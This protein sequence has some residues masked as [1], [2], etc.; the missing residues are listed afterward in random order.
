MRRLFIVFLLNGIFAISLGLPFIFLQSQPARGGDSISVKSSSKDTESG[1]EE[2]K[3]GGVS[4]SEDLLLKEELVEPQDEQEVK[5]Q[6]GEEL[7]RPLSIQKSAFQYG[8]GKPR[9]PSYEEWLRLEA[10]I[11]RPS[12]AVPKKAEL[13][14]VK[15]KIAIPEEKPIAEKPKEAEKPFSFPPISEVMPTEQAVSLALK[16]GAG[17]LT[18]DY[19]RIVV[20]S[21]RLSGSTKTKTYDMEGELLLFYRDITASA[22]RARLEEKTERILLQDDVL[23]QDPK[24][25]LSA[26]IV[27]IEFK[28][29]RFTAENFV[30]FK[31]KEKGKEPTGKDVPKR[32][33]VINIFKNEPTEIYANKLSYNWESEEM[34][35]EGEVKALQK[36]FTATMDKLSY[37]PRTKLYSLSGNVFVTLE[38]AEFL[39]TYELVEKEDED[40]ARALSEK[41]SVLKADSIETGE[42]TDV[43]LIR[44]TLAQPAEMSQEGKYLRALQIQ[45]DDFKK[46]LTA[47]G[48]VE[49]YQENGEWLKKGGLVEEGADEEVKKVLAKPVTSTSDYLSYDYDKRILRQWGAV[50][51]IS[52]NEALF[53]DELEYQEKGKVLTLKGNVTFYRGKDE[54]LFADEVIVDTKNNIMKFIGAVE[55]LM[56]GEESGKGEEME[57]KE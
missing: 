16:V 6:E 22:S 31:K 52:E 30:Q 21:G 27:N 19:A 13:P 8:T 38:D 50:K 57:T 24:Y 47:Q 20:E 25:E 14:P 5:A 44:G 11:L 45:I 53:A 32:R 17:D 2:I 29:K 37:N 26:D 36:D 43:T 40:I 39:F 48:G 54:Y 4:A 15:P 28:K 23:V 1:Q 9:Q 56:K 55:A 35:V 41:E 18:E 7:L 12:V 34:E 3:N 49:F 51:V 42:D 33:R 10:Q 46:L